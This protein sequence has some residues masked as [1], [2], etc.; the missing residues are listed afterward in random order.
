M[1]N[2]V[3]K[4][5]EQQNLSKQEMRQVADQ[6][7]QGNLSEAELGALLVALKIKGETIEEI[8]AI[9]E[10]MQEVAL[11]LPVSEL[12]AMDNCGTGGDRSGSFNISTTAAFVLAAA[13]IPVAKH[14][15]RSISSKSGSADVLAELG[16][17]ITQSEAEL[18]RLLNEVGIAFLFAPAVHPNM[19]YVMPVRQKLATP[20]VFNLI[21][22]LTNPAP[23]EAQLVG[24]YRGDLLEQIA[25]VLKNLGRK[26]AV[27]VHGAGGLDEATLAG[28]NHYAYLN[29]NQITLHQFAPEDVGLKQ[30]PLEA[31][32]GGDAKTNAV[33][34]KQVLKGEP[35]AYLDTTLLNAGL[36][37]FAYGR[38]DTIE[39]G[40]ELSREI[41]HSGAAF[42]KL[43]ELIEKQKEVVA[44]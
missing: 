6:I 33:I 40:V 43:Q 25:Y 8:T 17:G 37:L 42:A 30:M 32:R 9:A 35:S 7:F 4:V 2:L 1:E 3:Q 36:G 38:V 31:I 23:L 5:Y 34:L 13:G 16:V 26:R 19:K 27:V 10:A 14:G 15:N 39:K 44:G 18:S 24:I 21:G 20:T 22:P 41:I 12:R 11:K 29:Q 28:V